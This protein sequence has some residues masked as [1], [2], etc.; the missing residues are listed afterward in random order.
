MF[1]VHQVWPKPSCKAQWRGEEDKADRGR[2][3]KTTSGNGQAWSSASPRGSGEQGKMEKAGCKIICGAPTTLAVKGL[4]MMIMKWVILLPVHCNVDVS[5]HNRYKL[6]FLR[7][8]WWRSNSIRTRHNAM[9]FHSVIIRCD[10]MSEWQIELHEGLGSVN[11][12]YWMVSIYV[13]VHTHS[14]VRISL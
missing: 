7:Q 3:G 11:L 9:W 8:S 4:M 2:G 12:M 1:P 5:S 10:F 13:Y 14:L 6:F